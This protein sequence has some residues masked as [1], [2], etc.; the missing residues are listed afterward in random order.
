MPQAGEEGGA[1]NLMDRFSKTL[2]A[3]AA[4]SGLATITLSRHMP[5]LR[6]SISNDDEVVV[7]AHCVR[8]D[9]QVSGDH[10]MLLTRNR[11][12][13]SKQSKVLS[14]VRVEIEA[15]MT[16]LEDVRWAADPQLP[17]VELAFNAGGDRHRFRIDATHGKHMWRLDALL[18]KQFRRPSAAAASLASHARGFA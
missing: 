3:A 11:L 18:A 2:L 7:L 1:N 17:G 5:S 14:R 10:L 9:G 12:V 4:E 15:A 13:V 6:R 8:P 16:E